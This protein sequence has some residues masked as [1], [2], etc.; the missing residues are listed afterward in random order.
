MNTPFVRSVLLVFFALCLS[1]CDAQEKKVYDWIFERG[2]LVT[3]KSVSHTSIASTLG[4]KKTGDVRH[5]LDATYA[6]RTRTLNGD[7][8]ADLEFGLTKIKVDVRYGLAA[9]RWDSEDKKLRKARSFPYIRPF[10]EEYDRK[11]LFVMD[12]PG[13]TVTDIQ[14]VPQHGAKRVVPLPDLKLTGEAF[15]EGRRLFPK[16]PIGVGDSWPHT[17]RTF[18]NG[19]QVIVKRGT[20]T[21]VGV[22]QYKGRRCLKIKTTL[23]GSL[24][25][26]Q[27]NAPQ[28]DELVRSHQQ[29]VTLFEV[30][31]GLIVYEKGSESYTL[32][33]KLMVKDRGELVETETRSEKS[34]TEVLTVTYEGKS[35]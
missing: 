29:D 16:T 8:I 28:R 27:P 5:D 23:K 7:G 33:R 4:G 22:V 30:A 34:V 12:V 6:H 21:L 17:T 14:V 24:K 18:L 3:F 1:P 25:S 35:D 32:R 15:Q 13:R 20:R 26:L 2:R 9:I 11:Y 31:R 19:T 10:A